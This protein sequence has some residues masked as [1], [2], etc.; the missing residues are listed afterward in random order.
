MAGRLQ[1]D[2]S[3]NILVEFDYQN[4]VVEARVC[5]NLCLVRGL[6]LGRELQFDQTYCIFANPKQ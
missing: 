3:G 5:A 1:G 6:C 4:I 2:R